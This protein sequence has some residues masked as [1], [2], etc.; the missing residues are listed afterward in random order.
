MHRI[1]MLSLLVLTGCKGKA[2]YAKECNEGD[3]TACEAACEKGVAGKDGCLA[4]A[5]M[6]SNGDGVQKNQKR[7]A[8]FLERAC[9]G[10]EIDGCLF[11]ANLYSV[12]IGVDQSFA[13]AYEL[14]T[15]AVTPEAQANL[16]KLADALAACAVTPAALPGSSPWVPANLSDIS[17]KKYQS[18]PRDWQS[19]DFQ[20]GDF[21][22]DDPQ[23]LQY[24]WLRHS[25]TEGVI[26]AI[27][28]MDGNSIADI[29]FE[30]A[31]HCTDSGTCKPG[32]VKALSQGSAVEPISEGARQPEALTA[33]SPDNAG[34]ANSQE[35]APK[36]PVPQV[37]MGT[38]TL[39]GAMPPEIV[40]RVVRQ[41]YARFRLCYEQGLT[42]N[43]KLE[44]RV[45]VR[46]VIGRNGSVS[47]VSNGGSDIP[48]STVVE[49]VMRAY[50]GLSFPQPEG[51]IVTVVYP[52]LF[53]P[54][55]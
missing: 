3:P 20:C 32:A 4:A 41:N 29:A 12:G 18:A 22:L 38:A 14:W 45:T 21:N 39:S 52:I 11:A 50:Y 40:Q 42:K 37:R 27:G 6:L 36:P 33:K 51:G 46:F 10:G 28:D 8:F 24:G 9:D 13:R 1:L 35:A 43:P 7:A 19:G 5:R 23:W 15:K 2:E 31:I 47:H 34:G 26:R 17:G 16:G 55:G 53:S 48:D 25:S 49:C 44:G 30:V 54:G